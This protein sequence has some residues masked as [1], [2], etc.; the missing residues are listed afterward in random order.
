MNQADLDDYHPLYKSITLYKGKRWGVFD[1]GD[2]FALYYRKDIFDDPKLKSAY[3]AKFGKALVV[4]ATWDDYSQV[5]QFITDQLAPNVYGAAHFRKFGSPG[6][7]FSFLQQFRANGG[8]FFDDAMKAQLTTPAG[9]TTLDQMIAQNKA[10]LPGNNDL[11]A[12]AQWAAWLQGKV[13]MIFSWPP[14][15]RMSSN[16]AQRDKAI[17]FIPQSSIAD[18]V[19]YAVVPGGNGEMASGYVK[20]L[21]AGS[22]NEE[23]AYLF[24]QWVTAPPLSLVRT[25]LPYTLR[26]PYRLSTYKSEQYR[27]L[28]PAAKD[29][30]INLCECSNSGVVDMIMPGWQDYALSIDRMCSAVWGGEDPK[31]AL[32]K[33]AAE[34][35]TTTQRLGVAAQKAAYQEFLQVPGCYAD[36]TIEKLGK[37]AHVT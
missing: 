21:A 11:D 26:D 25:M 22:N 5:A 7:Q 29:Y 36:H 35:D 14:T 27:A 1:D 15:G 37:S 8:K 16:Y 4:P 10:S 33:A 31:A 3:Q 32:K 28:W 23:A 17:N 18:K 6:N 24:M 13:A 20:A 9:T 19:S 2:Q 34:W 12:V 30:L